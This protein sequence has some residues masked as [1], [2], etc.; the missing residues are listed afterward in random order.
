VGGDTEEKNC[1]ML[2]KN[3]HMVKHLGLK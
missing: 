2:H 3:C 1:E